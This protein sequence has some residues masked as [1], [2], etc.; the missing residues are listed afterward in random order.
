MKKILIMMSFILLTLVGY[1]QKIATS[2]SILAVDNDTSRF[3]IT[4]DTTRL[5]LVSKSGILYKLHIMGVP[6]GSIST[7]PNRAI[8]SSTTQT[9]ELSSDS[10]FEVKDTLGAVNIIMA[11]DLPTMSADF[12]FIAGQNAGG[13]WSGKNLVAIGSNSLQSNTTGSDN[14]AIGRATLISNTIGKRNIALGSY[15]GKYAVSLNDRLFI[16]NSKDRLNIEHDTMCT[17]IYGNYQDSLNYNTYLNSNVFIKNTLYQTPSGYYGQVMQLDSN[18]QTGVNINAVGFGSA[19]L[20]AITD[21]NSSNSITAVSNGDNSTGAIIGAEGFSSTAL[22][23]YSQ[24]YIP[25]ICRSKNYDT[26][27]IFASYTN[28][29]LLINA[30]GSIVSPDLTNAQIDIRGQQAYITKRYLDTTLSGVVGQV[31]A[32]GATGASGTNGAVGATGA[33]GTNGTNGATGATGATGALGGTGTANYVVKWTGTST[34]GQANQL[35]L[36]GDSCVFINASVPVNG[37]KLIIGGDVLPSSSGVYQL[38]VVGKL[39]ANTYTTSLTGGTSGNIQNYTSI[40]GTIDNNFSLYPKRRTTASSAGTDLYLS[41]SGATSG[42]SNMNSGIV[43]IGLTGTSNTN[44]S[45]GN[46]YGTLKFYGV[47]SGQGSGTTDRTPDSLVIINGRTS[48]STLTVLGGGRISGGLSIAGDLT[49]NYTHA[50]AGQDS[51]GT[52]TPNTVVNVDFK[53]QPS[54]IIV[55]TVNC[56]IQG[57]SI[58][59]HKAGDYYINISASISGANSDKWQFRLKTGST[60]LGTTIGRITTTGASNPMNVNKTWYIHGVTANQWVSI[61]VRNV[62]N[63]DDPTFTDFSVIAEKTL[64]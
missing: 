61:N 4:V 30:D 21:G 63:N 14:I 15:A 29:R 49:Y 10:L 23:A 9:G 47:R 57:D 43:H 52:Y 39:F 32:T 53:L 42:S 50:V 2:M 54:M 46:G 24:N 1:S 17:P 22:I 55:D 5:I 3:G 35:T 19:A 51:T 12:N 31:G 44:F 6:S 48:D 28:D 41:A 64:E 36:S 45:T 60:I 59:F 20:S 34:V 27:A 56:L 11:K 16:N 38:G 26:L 7:T 8:L 18:N 37:A 40:Q 33:S 58:Q 13:L 25:F 62:T